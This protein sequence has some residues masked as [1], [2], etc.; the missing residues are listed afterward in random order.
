M[1]SDKGSPPIYTPQ[2]SRLTKDSDSFWTRFGSLPIVEAIS[3]NVLRTYDSV[4]ATPVVGIG[5]R[6]VEGT[7]QSVLQ[8]VETYSNSL[9]ARFLDDVGCGLL[10]AVEKNFPI[11]QKTPEEIGKD[12]Q[13]KV[14]HGAETFVQSL[15]GQLVLSGLEFA[16]SASES[17]YNMIDTVEKE[18]VSQPQE[19][20]GEITPGGGRQTTIDE[21]WGIKEENK[22]E[23]LSIIRR[24]FRNLRRFVATP[25]YLLTMILKGIYNWVKDFD[26]TL[27]PEKRKEIEGRRKLTARRYYSN[28][29]S[30]RVLNAVPPL[31]FAF[32]MAGIIDISKLLCLTG[33]ESID[34]SPVKS[35]ND[36]GT[37]RGYSEYTSD[38]C[39]FDPDTYKSSEDED[40]VPP[41][42]PESSD[43]EEYNE[44]ETESDIE[45]IL[46]DEQSAHSLDSLPKNTK[47]IPKKVSATVL[48]TTTTDV[49]SSK[50]QIDDYFT[51]EHTKSKDQNVSGGGDVINSA[52]S[53]D[54]AVTSGD[55]VID[56]V[57]GDGCDFN[58]DTYKSSEDE[59]YVPPAD[60]ESSDSEE[61]NEGE[62][63]SDIEA[64]LKEEQSAHSMEDG[65]PKNAKR[66]PKTSTVPD[67]QTTGVPSLEGQLDGRKHIT[68]EH[69]NVGGGDV[70]N[71]V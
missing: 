32:K 2:T 27:D 69:L 25:F 11:V 6:I 15:A 57:T 40:Y 71:K 46:K 66:I 42:D 23:N 33:K 10:F 24:S 31:K 59:D 17:V 34:T 49:P 9:P 58:P 50:E 39:E 44:G 20:D 28:S 38:D 51:L 53:G 54:D 21:L 67:T 52:T 26:N 18:T 35:S 19:S 4:K 41:A 62:T 16:V 65:V 64:K 29:L 36:R 61:Y 22:P 7:C 47:R 1:S 70:I 63:E 5:M 14:N 37:K 55:D 56:P 8:E 30:S 45:A 43:S 68:G 48:V 13:T 60:P 3:K 12:I